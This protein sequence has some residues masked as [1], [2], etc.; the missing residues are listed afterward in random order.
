MQDETEI[1][2]SGVKVTDAESMTARVAMDTLA[3]A[4]AEGLEE[5]EGRAHTPSVLG[6]L[7]QDSDPAR[8]SQ[9]ANPIRG[10]RNPRRDADKYPEVKRSA[11]RAYDRGSRS[12]AAAAAAASSSSF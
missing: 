1:T 10:T 6:V 2:I 9:T 5:Q 3:N 11:P 8:E 4:L 7:E 12:T